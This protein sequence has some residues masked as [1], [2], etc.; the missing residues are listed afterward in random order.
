[1]KMM[2]VETKQIIDKFLVYGFCALCGRQQKQNKCRHCFDIIQTKYIIMYMALQCCP[3]SAFR[4][5]IVMTVLMRRPRARLGQ[6]ALQATVEHS[7]F[8]IICAGIMIL[9]SDAC[10][11]QTYAAACMALHWAR[12]KLWRFVLLGSSTALVAV[13]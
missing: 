5:I 8:D 11:V 10:C 9:G 3:L 4:F 13:L 6:A 12:L 1:M 2:R 7:I